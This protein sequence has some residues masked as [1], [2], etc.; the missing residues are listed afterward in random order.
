MLTT[1]ASSSQHA[2][3]HAIS[4]FRPNRSRPVTGRRAMETSGAG[5]GDFGRAVKVATPGGGLVEY[6]GLREGFAGS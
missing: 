1:R 4:S 6:A 5:A 2:S 3:S